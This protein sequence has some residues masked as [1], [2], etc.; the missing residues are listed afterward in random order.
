MALTTFKTFTNL[1]KGVASYLDYNFNII[2]NAFGIAGGFATLNGSGKVVETALLA[3]V[4]T[5]AA[6][7]TLLLGSTVGIA[8]TNIPKI[9]T[10]GT[11]NYNLAAGATLAVASGTNGDGFAVFSFEGATDLDCS[12]QAVYRRSSGYI[13]LSNFG[14]SSKAGEVYWAIFK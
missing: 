9:N 12:I 6:N 5:L 13:I 2:K 8:A 1:A 14:S 4:A 10:V 3:D 11:A 7:S